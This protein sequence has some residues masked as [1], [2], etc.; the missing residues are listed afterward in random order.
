MPSEL[1]AVFVIA[2]V[3]VSALRSRELSGQSWMFL[4]VLVP[5]WRFF[6]DVGHALKLECRF[7]TPQE[8]GEW[9]EV[10]RRP[11][12]AWHS[13]LFNPSGNLFLAQQSLL[14]RLESDISEL[15]PEQTETFEQATS[16][17]LVK[18]LVRSHLAEQGVPAG[19]TF[20]FRISRALEEAEIFV[21]SALY[22]V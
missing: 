13:F 21:R 4:R 20:Q 7:G 18:R 19:T 10:L 11:T 5:S 22:Q 3:V 15:D 14:Q 6:E 9:H 17:L 8:Q 1:L 2:L 16:F 12:P